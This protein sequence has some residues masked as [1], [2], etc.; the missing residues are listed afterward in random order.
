MPKDADLISGKGRE[1]WSSLV[2]EAQNPERGKGDLN[3]EREKMKN[4]KEARTAHKSQGERKTIGLGIEH[5]VVAMGSRQWWTAWLGWLKMG[6]GKRWRMDGGR[7]G[8][9]DFRLIAWLL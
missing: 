2:N 3:K 6:G 8:R 7:G 9:G 1:V 5:D 4:K